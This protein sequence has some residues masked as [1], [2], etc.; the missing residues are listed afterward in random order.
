MG[1]ERTLLG[2][3]QR[4]CPQAGGADGRGEPVVHAA[5]PGDVWRLL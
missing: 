4:A 1:R 3:E 5:A 2:L